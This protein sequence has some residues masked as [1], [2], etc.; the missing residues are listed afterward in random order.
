MFIAIHKINAQ[1]NHQPNYKN[2]PVTGAELRHQIQIDQNS[3]NR[4]E[5]KIHLKAIN[6]QPQ[7]GKPK[8]NHQHFML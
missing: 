2:N 1:S 3:D 6:A 7:P 5:G 4:Q 8:N